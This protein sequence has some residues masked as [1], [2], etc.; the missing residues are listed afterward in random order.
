[1][2]RTT[3][4]AILQAFVISTIS[5]AG[6]INL[7]TPGEIRR[8]EVFEKVALEKLNSIRKS[9]GLS[10]L[11]RNELLAD[12]AKEHS[13]YMAQNNEVGH[14]E[15]PKGRGFFGGT[16]DKRME[17]AGYKNAALGEAIAV[18][19]FDRSRFIT[20]GLI[21]APYHRLTLLDPRFTDVGIAIFCRGNSDEMWPN[22]DCFATYELGGNL[23]KRFVAFPC[24]SVKVRTFFNCS[25]VP[26]PC[27]NLESNSAQT[28]Y[29]FT[30]QNCPKDIEISAKSGKTVYW[31]SDKNAARRD[32]LMFIPLAPLAPDSRFEFE[33]GEL[34]CEF[35][36]YRSD[37]FTFLFEPQNLVVKR[38]GDYFAK[39]RLMGEGVYG[40]MDRK[41]NVEYHGNFCKFAIRLLPSFESDDVY[42]LLFNLKDRASCKKINLQLVPDL[43]TPE[44]RP[45]TYLIE[46]SQ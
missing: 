13:L 9:L 41:V 33:A 8:Y 25:E 18:V 28:G 4:V 12:A 42:Y 27:I 37:N 15:N 43:P 5:F 21:D 31:D 20:E 17:K 24:N 36:T 46:L 23:E 32:Y 38:E 35:F 2:M 22:A 45:I 11:S 44:K 29:I 19:P 3:V 7:P 6:P 30:F 10:E 16:P 26:S 34:K 40:F 14:G 1:M 39:V